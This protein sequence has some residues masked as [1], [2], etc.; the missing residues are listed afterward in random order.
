MT[1]T[2]EARKSV[3]PAPVELHDEALDRVAGGATQTKHPGG[4]NF[5]FADGSVR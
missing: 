3:K 2:N 5:L 4:A 1:K